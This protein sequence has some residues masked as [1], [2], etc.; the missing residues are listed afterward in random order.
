[1]INSQMNRQ[2]KTAISIRLEA[3][4]LEQMS[5]A[6]DTFMINRT[7]LIERCVREFLVKWWEREGVAIRDLDEFRKQKKSLSRE[8]EGY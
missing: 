1:M 3:K 5:L 4:M 2:N 6:C 8:G 7:S